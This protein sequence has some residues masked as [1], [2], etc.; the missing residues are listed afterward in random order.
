[1]TIEYKDWAIPIRF[2]GVELSRLA[3]VIDHLGLYN[4]LPD[5]SEEASLWLWR[6][7]KCHGRRRYDTAENIQKMVKEV[8][9]LVTDNR[10]KLLESVPDHFDG[11]FTNEHLDLW[12][13]DL[14]T[15]L[16]LCQ[17]NQEC[18]WECD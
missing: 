12:V 2:E 13:K 11:P 16:N 8:L 4:N 18:T 10:Q 1:M 15:I 3:V 14:E 6:F 5:I 9:Q 7:T 17:G